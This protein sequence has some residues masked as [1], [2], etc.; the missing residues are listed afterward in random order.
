MSL[1]PPSSQEYSLHL[2]RLHA[3]R[4][5]TLAALALC[6]LIAPALL[7]IQLPQVYLL[8]V[9]LLAAGLTLLKHL[10]SRRAGCAQNGTRASELCSQLL[11]DLATLSAMLYLSGGATN[12]L[13]SLLL[14]PVAFAAL[15]LPA[16]QVAIVGTAAIAAYSLLMLFY[17]PLPIADVAR[18]TQLHLVGMWL[19]FVVSAGLIG[20]IVLRMSQRIRMRDAELA[21]AREQ[22]LRDERVTAIGTLAA[23]AA[24]EL[25][26]PLATMALIAGEFERDAHLPAETRADAALL[27][28]QI[29]LCKDIISGLSRRAG[30][31]RLENIERLPADRWLDRL[32]QHWH[33]LC[34]QADSRLEVVSPGAAPE[35]AADPRLAQALLNLLNNAA[36]AS[37]APVEIH[38][39]WDEACISMEVL[40]RGPGLPPEVLDLCGRSALPTHAD[41]CGIGLL[42]TCSAINQLGGRLH[43]AQR[44]GGGARARIDL[45]RLPT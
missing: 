27:R 25:G 30:A 16:V 43:L 41:G 21:A 24:H 2:G 19:T 39:G 3:A 37:A 34:P 6:V 36:R 40:D 29:G 20:W 28:Q 23:G 13:I 44:E 14:P 42:L 33:S 22:A 12:P 26:T 8:G 4:F 5:F 10:D 35:L 32:R 1:L 31:E 17:L 15:A 7:G 38:L 11:F 9:L 45:P 18:A